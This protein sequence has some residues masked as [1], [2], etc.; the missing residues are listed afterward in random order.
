MRSCCACVF[1]CKIFQSGCDKSPLGSPATF[2]TEGWATC[3]KTLVASALPHFHRG[4]L[5]FICFQ[6]S[7]WSKRTSCLA[8]LQFLSF[9]GVSLLRSDEKRNLSAIFWVFPAFLVKDGLS[10]LLPSQKKKSTYLYIWN[11]V[12]GQENWIWGNVRTSVEVKLWHCA[13]LTND[14]VP[15]LELF[16][17]SNTS[18]NKKGTCNYL[19]IAWYY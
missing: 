16:N 2:C 19:K 10:L 3:V 8:S 9:I 14:M 15:R 5:E 12:R 6:S 1:W 7:Q 18:T 13:A 11:S 4:G 17:H